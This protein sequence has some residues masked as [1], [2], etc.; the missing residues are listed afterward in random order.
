MNHQFRKVRRIITVC[1]ALA[2]AS[3]LVNA[4][5]P[6]R[7][8]K[9]EDYYIL[10]VP[11]DGQISPNGIEVAYVVTNIENETTPHSEIWIADADGKHARQITRSINSSKS[12][13]WSPDGKSIAFLS[14]RPESKDDKDAKRQVQIL[15]LDGGEARQ[16]TYL[17]NGVDSF[18]WSPDGLRF[19][20]VSTTSAPVR[21]S[22][23]GD[24]RHY[25]HSLYKQD[26]SGFLTDAR[27]HI[28]VADIKWRTA[29]QVTQG[30]GWDDSNP[31]WSPDGRK[32]V[33]LS[34]RSGK[35]WEDYEEHNYVGVWVVSE[36]GGQPLE[37]NESHGALP[38][39]P[40]WSPDGKLI[41]FFGANVF[42]DPPTLYLISADGSAHAKSLIGGLD[43]N[44]ADLQWGDQGRSVYFVNMT[45]GTEQIFR[46][47]GATGV[48]TQ[49]T[50]GDQGIS[51]LAV[52][53]R[54]MVYSLATFVR[55]AEIMI[56]R[57]DG[58]EQR[59]VSDVNGAFFSEVA[60]QPV[61][62]LAYKSKDGT[63][64]DGFLV[65]PAGWEPGKKYPLILMIHGG[66]E[67]M[68]KTTWALDMQNLAA[69]GYAVFF[70]NPRGSS[71][72]GTAFMRGSIKEWGG[73]IYTDV[74]SGVDTALA[75]NA[76]VDADK[77]GVTGCSFG[78]F[79]TNWI[80]TQTI[81]FKAAVP[82]CSISDFISNEGARDGFYG[83]A[84]EF[85]G[86]LYT[87]FDLY[88]KYS[89]IRYAMNVKTPTLILHGEADQRVPIEQAEEWFRAL[90]HFNVPSELVI[91]PR[92][93][94]SG[95]MHDGEPKHIVAAMYWMDYWFDRYVKRNVNAMA[96]DAVKNLP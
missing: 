69:Q 65:K 55:P 32:I 68:F 61:D 47:D 7:L 33:F 63:S 77:L 53:K 70:T 29:K 20:C 3:P 23:A 74:M 43:I 35:A 44:A 5:N 82:K 22:D 14:L 51:N 75:Q 24:E 67:G 39:S 17:K 50:T 59:Q 71:G 11:S 73:N 26:P 58:T 34:D 46:V 4:Q 56:A 72:Y 36:D 10:K 83:H 18:S 60:V 41:A 9:P 84:Y 78:G 16:A 19:V 64:I 15:F 38:S 42:G 31:E 93:F 12:P 87:N 79:M 66:P 27:K 6:R 57:L 52:G 1:V 62:R 48:E 80:I 85:G 37:V 54:E 25:I 2:V 86:D 28:W 81:R 8:I 96:P 45:K 76:W 88:W 95:I 90:H 13:R 30:D 94:H 49:L 91:F 92:E 89:P 21:A 40:R